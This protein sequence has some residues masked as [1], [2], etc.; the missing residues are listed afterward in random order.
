M[1]STENICAF[2][3]LVHSYVKTD[4]WPDVRPGSQAQQTSE[5]TIPRIEA[6]THTKPI[7]S[8]FGEQYL[9]AIS[10]ISAEHSN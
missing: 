8:K 3:G 1:S 10:K 9:M 7:G 4:T 2:R 5:S 6:I